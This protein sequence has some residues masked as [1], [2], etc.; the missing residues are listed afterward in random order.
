MAQIKASLKRLNG[1]LAH[2]RTYFS[3]P[4]VTIWDGV[5]VIVG[6]FLVTFWQKLVWSEPGAAPMGFWKALQDAA[7]NSLMIWCLFCAFF[8]ALSGFLSKKMNLVRLSGLVGAAALPLVFTT[9]FSAVTWQAAIIL[10]INTSLDYWSIGQ[11]VIS[12]F[13]LILSWP[14]LMGYC[15]MTY[16]LKYKQVVAILLV[17]LMLMFIIV[18]RFL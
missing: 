5:I 4:E 14:G 16:G 6:L 10:G 15:L 2:P 8:F 18:G 13:G 3:D 7:I 9:L 17:I 1:L 12:W 11:L